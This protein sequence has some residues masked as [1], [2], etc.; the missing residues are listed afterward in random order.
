MYKTIVL[1]YDGSESGQR[2]L[3]DCQ[4][5]G[6]WS[7]AQLHLVAVMTPPVALVAVEAWA[8]S[9]NVDIGEKAEFEAVLDA[10][11]KRLREAGL[12]AQGEVVAGTAVEVIA[13]TATAVQADLIVLGH[14]HLGSWAARWWRGP[15]VSQSLIEVAPCSVLIVITH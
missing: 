11:L 15:S 4:E 13:R 7:Q 10:G 12:Q 5:I 14:K 1:A 2:A 8:Y 6:Q 9:P 3:L